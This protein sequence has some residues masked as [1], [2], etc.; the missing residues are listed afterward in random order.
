MIRILVLNGFL[1]LDELPIL[2]VG[3]LPRKCGFSEEAY[4][5][6]GRILAM[7]GN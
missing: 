6:E 3:S 4:V 2:R 7:G 1:F 5:I